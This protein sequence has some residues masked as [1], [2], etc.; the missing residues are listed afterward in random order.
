M[1]LIVASFLAIAVALSG[2]IGMVIANFVRRF[3]VATES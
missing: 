3:K 1:E 2:H